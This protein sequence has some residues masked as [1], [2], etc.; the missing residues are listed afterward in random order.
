MKVNEYCKKARERDTGCEL[1]F[2]CSSICS[3]GGEYNPPINIGEI[4]LIEISES[5]TGAVND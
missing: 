4:D 5:F 1:R 3:I 2:V